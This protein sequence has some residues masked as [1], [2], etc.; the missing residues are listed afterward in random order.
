MYL[1]NCAL[2]RPLD[3]R[4]QFRVRIEAEA[5]ESVIKDVERGGARLLSSDVLVAESTAALDP[6]RRDFASE[7]LRLAESSVPLS[8]AVKERA[9]SYRAA[10]IKAFDA[11]HL[12]SAVEGGADFF[13]TTDDRFL[14][15][16]SAANT[17]GVRVVTPL[18]LAV[19][20]GL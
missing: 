17:G 16:A 2:Q 3:N 8:R 13:C 15:K 11:L 7:T 1:D 20:L 6:T 4:V 5:V 12:A 9:R 19:A 10:G 14:G 18:E